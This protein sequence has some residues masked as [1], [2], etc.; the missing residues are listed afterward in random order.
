MSGALVAT[1]GMSN[2]LLEFQSFADRSKDVTDAVFAPTACWGCVVAAWDTDSGR[3]W[4]RANN[5]LRSHGYSPEDVDVVWLKV[6]RLKD[7]AVRADD[8]ERILMVLKVQWPNV[9]QVFVSD[10]IYTGYLGPGVEPSGGWE[11]G[12]AVR[13]FVLNHQGETKPWIGWGPYL[14]ANGEAVRADGLA[15]LRSD[16]QDDMLH[17]SE[18]GAVKVA[19]LLIE[20]FSTAPEATWFPR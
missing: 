20:F 4:R 15:W 19:D 3:G 1:V 13:A 9:R 5:W 8:L 11:A 2:T 16:Y 10:R 14:W 6:T 7:E 18:A 12:P 17:P